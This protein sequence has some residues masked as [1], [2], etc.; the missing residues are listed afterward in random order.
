MKARDINMASGRLIRFL[1]V[2]LVFFNIAASQARSQQTA[3]EVWPE[4]DTYFRLS[5]RYR[6]LLMASR[7]ADRDSGDSAWEAGPS[8]DITLKRIVRMKLLGLD[9][10]RQKY[11]TF[12]VGYRN[13]GQNGSPDENRLILEMTP[14]FPLPGSILISDRN[15]IDLRWK[16]NFS[17]RYRNRISAERAS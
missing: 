4:L 11:L 1:T 8:L 9:P 6:I 7:A 3:N 2:L 14:R 15:R 12:R 17:W 13:L 16:G 10:E 5:Q